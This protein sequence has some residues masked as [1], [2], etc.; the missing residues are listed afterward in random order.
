MQYRNLGEGGPTV[1]AIG[2]GGMVL[3]PGVYDEVDDAQSRR[4]LQAGIESGLTFLDTADIYGDGHNERLLSQ[5]L[6]DHRDDLVVATKF[7]MVLEGE[8]AGDVQMSRNGTPEYV[9][10]SIDASLD[11]LGVD[12]ID[13]YYLHRVDPATPL[14]ETVQAMAELVDEGK[15]KH[16]ALSEVSGD[17]LRRANDI[18]PITAVQ[19]EYSLF[20]RDPERDILPVCRELGVGFVPFSPLGRGLL[21]GNLDL[22]VTDGFRQ[23]LPRFQDENLERNLELAAQAKEVATDV[24]VSLPQ[25]ALSWL[26]HQGDHVVPIPGTRSADHLKSNLAAADIELDETTLDRIEDVLP[27]GA[28]ADS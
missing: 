25:L 12:Q 18:H 26:L 27:Y 15:V 8:A 3:S 7:G 24:G 21:T 14:E 28:V 11:R 6:Q 2:F 13:L 9:R 22:E 4:T 5:V 10:E 20:H 17:E 19:S 16:I 23:S 1:S